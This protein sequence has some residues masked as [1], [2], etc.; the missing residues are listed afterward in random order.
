M[1]SAALHAYAVA[2]AALFFKHFMTTAIQGRERLRTRSFAYPEDAAQWRGEHHD[3]PPSPLWDRAAR[4]LRNDGENHAL[5]FALGGA[6]VALGC[7]DRLGVAYFAVYAVARWAH[8]VFLLW[9]RQPH[10]NRA[11]VVSLAVLLALAVH[12]TIAGLGACALRLA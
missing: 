5:F 11:Y 7:P 4:L 6:Y 9:P 2:V 3:G 10:R 8:A 12:V 1:H